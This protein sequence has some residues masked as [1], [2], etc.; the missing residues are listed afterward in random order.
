MARRETVAITSAE[1]STGRPSGWSPKTVSVKTSWTSSGGVSSIIAI[2]S[3]T[4]SRSASMS[5]KRGR[6]DHVGHDVERR[7]DVLVEDARVD[8]RVVAAVAAF[9]SPP[10]ASKISAISSAE[11]LP[12]PLKS[13][14]SRKCERPAWR[15]SSSRD[16]APIQTPIAAERTLGAAP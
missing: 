9:S 14:C 5:A 6:E 8:D 7:L 1:P 16:P 10:I 4:T 12:V 13:R 3:R 15:V 2:S 11:Y